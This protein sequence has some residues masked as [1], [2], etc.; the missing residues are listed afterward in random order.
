MNNYNDSRKECINTLHIINLLFI[1]VV[2]NFLLIMSVAVITIH[3]STI[4]DSIT[5]NH[6]NDYSNTH[7]KESFLQTRKINTIIDGEQLTL[8]VDQNDNVYI[9]EECDEPFTAPNNKPYK[10]FDNIGFAEQGY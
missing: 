5:N 7:N 10:W 2:L 9:D 3:A 8:F 4:S 6:G 1:I